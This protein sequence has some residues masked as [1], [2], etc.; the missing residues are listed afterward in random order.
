MGRNSPVYTLGGM[1]GDGIHARIHILNFITFLTAS[2]AHK[3][4]TNCF[5]HV[6]SRILHKI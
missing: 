2:N 5:E 3:T 6:P 1:H 4:A